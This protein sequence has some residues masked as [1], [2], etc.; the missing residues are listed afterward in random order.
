MLGKN[1]SPTNVKLNSEPLPTKANQSCK[2]KGK[3]FVKIGTCQQRHYKYSNEL[4]NRA[5]KLTGI[6]ERRGY[7]RRELRKANKL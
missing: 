1:A 5:G 7:E 3:C 4:D 6:N 2:G